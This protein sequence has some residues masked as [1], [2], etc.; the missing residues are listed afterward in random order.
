MNKN[1]KVKTAPAPTLRLLV[2]ISTMS[3]NSTMNVTKTTWLQGPRDAAERRAMTRIKT[4][5]GAT[6]PALR[7]LVVISSMST[8]S[9][10]APLATV[11]VAVERR[12]ALKVPAVASVTEKS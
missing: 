9:A 8:N 1:Q 2:L 7:L 4:S 5:I 12:D 3:T 6:A 10:M 11:E